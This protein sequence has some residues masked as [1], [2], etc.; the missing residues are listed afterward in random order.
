[1]NKNSATLLRALSLSFDVPTFLLKIETKVKQK[2]IFLNT[3]LIITKLQLLRFFPP[4]LLPR[5]FGIAAD[6][7]L[8][9]RTL[10]DQSLHLLSGETSIV[11]LLQSPGL[12]V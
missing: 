8:P 12:V 11:Y 7:V 9:P 5:P 6:V 10:R 3:T 4:F 1:M 2:P